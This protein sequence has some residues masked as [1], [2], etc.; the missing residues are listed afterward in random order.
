MSQNLH[1][2]RRIYEK[3]SLSKETVDANPLQQFQTWFYDAKEADSVNEVNAMTLTTIG[4]DG[5]PK[6]RVVLLK[7]YDEYG[8]Y[9]F[10]NYHS[11]KGKA[12]EVNPKVS[13]SFFWPA[14]ERQV[15]IKGIASKTTEDFSTN[16][17]NSR[18]KGS[19]LGALVSNQSEVVENR[20]VLDDRLKGLEK[21]FQDKEITRPKFW[22]GYL[23]S[24]LS[25][26][27]WQ[28]RPNRLHDRI[29]YTLDEFD[30]KIDRLEP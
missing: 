9:F 18:P 8:F 25:I 7:Q 13:L 5:F 12:I 14:L 6:G 29:L 22:G 16:Y 23:V 3:G 4:L 20:T 17:F 2:F 27:F 24:P 19:Q 28:G 10:T 11:E 1:N 21:E 26:E 30:W 15:I